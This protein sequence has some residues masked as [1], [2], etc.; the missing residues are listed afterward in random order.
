MA[1]LSAL[2]GVLGQLPQLQVLYLCSTFGLRFKAGVHLCALA[3]AFNE[4]L[5]GCVCTRA[6][7]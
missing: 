6:R 3:A 5:S 1:G 4:Q 7:A 2:A